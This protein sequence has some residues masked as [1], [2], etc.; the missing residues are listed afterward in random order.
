MENQ[1][2]CLLAETKGCGYMRLCCHIVTSRSLID[3]ST[4]RSDPS[5]MDACFRPLYFTSKP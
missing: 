5:Y 1:I 4:V 3:K 2:V